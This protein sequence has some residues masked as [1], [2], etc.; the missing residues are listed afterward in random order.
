MKTT[1]VIPARYDSKRF[2][3]KP[4]AV[5]N[6]KT[7]LERVW[8]IASFVC[9]S[10]PDCS[11]IVATEEPSDETHENDIIPFCKKNSI[12]VVI[13]SRKC[14]SGSDRVW[15]FVSNLEN[16][17][18]V[19]VNL[20]GDVPTCPPHFVIQLIE[21]L[22]TDPTAAVATICTRLNWDALD[23]LRESKKENPFSGTTVIASTQNDAIWFSKSI[24]PA[25]RNE[26]E[27]RKESNLSPVLRHVGLYAYRFDALQFFAAS[28][29]GKY[30]RLEQLE[31]LRFLENGKKIRLVYGQYPPGYEQTIS[32]VDTPEDLESVS[33]IVNECGELLDFYANE[34]WRKVLS[35]DC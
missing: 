11:A 2:P 24:V 23:A 14:R 12:P 3:G 6:G 15:S 25:I 34:D 30:E 19:V 9:Q 18:E 10:I 4:L 26:E 21:A 33:K 7:I 1:I 35:Y 16:R 8:E 22:K 31:Q 29:V 13:T 20:Q 5:L 28:D 17:P 32:G 27:L